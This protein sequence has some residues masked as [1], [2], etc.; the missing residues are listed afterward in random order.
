LGRRKVYRSNAARQAAYRRRKCQSGINHRHKLLTSDRWLLENPARERHRYFQQLRRL[1]DASVDLIVT[2]PPYAD[3]RSDCFEVVRAKDYVDWFLPI[4]AELHR[5]L[6]DTGSFVLN[7]KEGVKNGERQTYVYELVIAL[8]AQGWLWIDDYIWSKPNGVP[9]RWANRLCDRWEHLYHLVRKKKFAFYPDAVRQPR[10]Y[11]EFR[12]RENKRK[13]SKTGS[14][15]TI[16][17]GANDYSTPTVLPGNVIT[18]ATVA[19][20]VGH[21]AAFPVA[22][23]EWFIKLFTV[24]GDTVLDPFLGS[25]TTAIAAER[26]GRRWIGCEKSAEYVEVAM[27]RIEAERTRSGRRKSG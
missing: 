1:P 12:R 3:K 16:N 8:K 21:P 19:H 23:P 24:E 14:G 15:F 9:G 17:H 27:G 2:S 5:I 7:L 6:K 22:L 4:S 18:P 13:M 11:F 25:G 10:K 20:N 26:L